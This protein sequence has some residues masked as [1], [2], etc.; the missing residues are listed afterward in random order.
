MKTAIVTGATRGIGKAIAL[1]L[2]A[3]KYNLVVVARDENQLST[4]K[5]SIEKL[6]V[7]C[8]PIALDLSEATAPDF[9]VREAVKH[10][11]SIN[12]LVNNA[13]IAHSASISETDMK[14][15]DAILKINAR[16]PF[17]LCKAAVPELK[18]CENPVIINISS[19]VG[20]KGYVGQA[21]YS[22]SKHALMGFSKVLA[23]EVQNDGIKVHVISPGGV[24]TEMVQH[25]R[26][27]INTGD[28]IQVD[29]IAELVAFLIT[30]KGKGTIDHLYIRRQ[31]S[32]AFDL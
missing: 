5:Q 24:N 3:L 18:K 19:V 8:L 7:S 21:A 22:A 31:N 25:M 11:G 2:A 27:D 30:R 15:W 32:T 28:L 20:F 26:P 9:I 16:A 6:N 12:V 14:T 4:L 23:K 10:F 13:G 17:F 29:E 1:K